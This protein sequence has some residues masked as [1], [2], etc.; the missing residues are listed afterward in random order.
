LFIILVNFCM[1]SGEN[2]SSELEEPE[3]PEED[4]EDDEGVGDFRLLLFFLFLVFGFFPRSL[5]GEQFPP[6]VCAS[7]AT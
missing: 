3:E 7:R 1:V 2:T 5:L 4:E 6:E